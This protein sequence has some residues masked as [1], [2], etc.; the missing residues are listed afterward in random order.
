M[1]VFLPEMETSDLVATILA[2]CLA[3]IASLFITPECEDFTS[4][5]TVTVA[6][7]LFVLM[8]GFTL[9]LEQME[10]ET[11]LITPTHLLWVCVAMTVVTFAYM[12]HQYC[13]FKTLIH[14]IK[15]KFYGPHPLIGAFQ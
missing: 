11:N 9:G 10:T 7:L 1:G 5:E 3:Q 14:T 15:Q 8:M 4:A 2:L 6:H 13:R 12:A